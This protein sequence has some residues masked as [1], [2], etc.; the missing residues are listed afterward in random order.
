MQTK[1][2]I[3][4]TE[5]KGAHTHHW[6]TIREQ[7]YLSLQ[8]KQNVINMF[9]VDAEKKAFNEDESLQL[10]L[11]NQDRITFTEFDTTYEN[12]FIL[13]NQI[14]LE[15]RDVNDINEIKLSIELGEEV[16]K[17]QSK[18]LSISNDGTFCA[19]GG[20]ISK[21][22]FY[23]VDLQN[24]QQ[25]QFVSEVLTHTFAPCFINGQTELVA[26]GD[27]KKRWVEVWDIKK[28][29]AVKV[30][31]INKGDVECSAST[32]NI[33]A[34]ATMK[35]FLGLWDVRSWE[36]IYSKEFSLTPKSL[37][38]TSDSKFLTIAG[39]GGEKCIVMEIK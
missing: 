37:H 25:H 4:K 20:G 11:A 29:K 16:R 26:I 19:I 38:L 33:L 31:E 30:L 22:Y 18:Q 2:V 3:W 1:R 36:M 6:V 32:N 9:V 12:I 7:K 5:A 14:I 27:W 28:Q 23:V 39:S 24:A 8:T 10:C 34:V 35:K 15:K 17:S 13:K 21:R